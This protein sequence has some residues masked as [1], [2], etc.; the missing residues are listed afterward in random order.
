MHHCLSILELIENICDHLQGD[1]DGPGTLAALARTC[2]SFHD[3]ALN[4][5]WAVQDDGLVNLMRC[6]PPDLFEFNNGVPRLLRPILASDWERPLVYMRRIRS[7]SDLSLGERPMFEIFGALVASLPGDVASLFPKLT[8]LTWR[9][10][11]GADDSSWKRPLLSPRLTSLSISS[12]SM[13][14]LLPAINIPRSCPTL[15]KLTLSSYPMDAETLSAFSSCLRN[16]F[17]LESV[18]VEIP[19]MATLQHLSQLESLTSLTIVF[20]GDFVLLPGAS[21]PFIALNRLDIKYEVAQVIDFFESCSE[22]PLKDID[23]RL[24]TCPS[25]T[26]ID[27]LHAA[28]R[29][30]CS[31]SALSSLNIEIDENYRLEPE[32]DLM[33]VH[34]LR[35]LFCFTNVTSVRITSL[36]FDMDDQGMKELAR[37]WPQLRVLGLGFAGMND[38]TE[39]QPR[40]SLRSLSVLAQHCPALAELNLTLDATVV[41]E[42]D[43]T[44]V[45]QLALRY[46]G[47]G[48]SP[49]T[50]TSLVA[51]FI[52]AL[53]PSLAQIRTFGDGFID[54]ADSPLDLQPED[55]A[56]HHLWTE[57]A[58]QIP[59]IAATREAGQH[60]IQ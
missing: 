41:P 40:F 39:L 25:T 27:R 22:A 47:V 33:T 24:F 59:I 54:D 23:M 10:P 38:D 14:T 16:L 21:L 49:I 53:F 58:A 35:I 31:H 55:T 36:G 8:S 56:Y 1:D 30:G 20:P 6:M 9:E 7:L 52:S 60:G 51:E 26:V 29:D 12:D 18:D 19:D 3:P 2:R 5:L 46:F 37:A 4:H 50:S 32:S 15:K 43:P 42:P 13:K 34:S 57:V 44:I 28:L 48:R 45:P 11:S 17:T